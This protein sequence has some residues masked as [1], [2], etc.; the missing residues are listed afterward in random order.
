[1]YGISSYQMT[2]TIRCESG[3][4]RKAWNKTDPHGGAKG[5]G[6]FLQPTFDSYSKKAGIS[7]GDVWDIKDSLQTMAY[8]FSIGQAKQW[9]E[10]RRLFSGTSQSIALCKDRI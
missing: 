1:M 2:E 5:I 8:M 9:T 10:W 4:K 7:D 3:F 6:Q